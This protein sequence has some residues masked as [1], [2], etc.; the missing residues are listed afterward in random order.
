VS[1]VKEMAQYGTQLFQDWILRTYLP[2]SKSPFFR[3]IM[4]TIMDFFAALLAKLHGPRT[5]RGG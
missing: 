3:E 1:R 2:Q 5:G 4:K